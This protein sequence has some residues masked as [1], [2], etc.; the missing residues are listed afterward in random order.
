MKR[1]SAYARRPR[2]WAYMA[3]IKTQPCML[4]YVGECDGPVEADHAG[5]RGLGQKADDRTC[6]PLCRGHHR[7][8]HDGIGWWLGR[9][10]R[11]A[12]DEW[13]AELQARYSA[14]G[15]WLEGL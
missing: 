12:L 11:P 6:V 2:D 9:T 4:A 10:Q 3:W 8:R 7:W 5:R 1:R 14:Q 15:G 13:I